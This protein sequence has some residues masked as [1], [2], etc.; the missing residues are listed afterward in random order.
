MQSYQKMFIGVRAGRYHSPEPSSAEPSLAE[1]SSEPSP[2]PSSEPSPEPSSAEPSLAEPSSEPSPESEPV[3]ESEPE[4]SSF[5]WGIGNSSGNGIV[6]K[7][8]AMSGIWSFDK[9]DT[10]LAQLPL[11]KLEISNDMI[12]ENIASD[13]G[14]PAN[15]TGVIEISPSTG[16]SN[17]LYE[18]HPVHHSGTGYKNT[19]ATTG[20]T[21]H[22]NPAFLVL[23]A[24]IQFAQIQLGILVAPSLQEN[25]VANI[26][27][28]PLP[29]YTMNIKWNVDL[30]G[31]IEDL[32]D[33]ITDFFLGSSSAK[34]N[35]CR[36]EIWK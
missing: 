14:I 10:T 30:E 16:Y 12:W 26:N 15:S 19:Q 13:L 5:Y 35:Q 28:T 9:L 33:Y 25:S 23:P 8:D 4:S 29:I 22:Y 18:H 6:V 27:T 11:F 1:P 17:N 21:I 3:P 20:H 32:D 24:T 31:G 36:F 2:K 34:N 7:Y